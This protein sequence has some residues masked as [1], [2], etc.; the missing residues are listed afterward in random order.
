MFG[1]YLLEACFSLMRSR[2][3]VELD[4]RGGREEL[5]E[6]EEG[7]L[8][9]EYIVLKKNLFSIEGNFSYILIIFTPKSFYIFPT[10]LLT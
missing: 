2:K 5:G 8:Y 4:G 3:G 10:F 9:S 7:K 6:I 1:C